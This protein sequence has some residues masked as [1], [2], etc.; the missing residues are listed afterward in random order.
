MFSQARNAYNSI[1]QFVRHVTKNT[2]YL[3]NFPFPELYKEVA[4]EESVSD[5]DSE[6]AKTTRIKPKSKPRVLR[7]HKKP[8][9][10]SSKDPIDEKGDEGLAT[11]TAGIPTLPRRDNA[12][13]VEEAVTGIEESNKEEGT[14]T[15][16]QVRER[17]NVLCIGFSFPSRKNRM[18][19]YSDSA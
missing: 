4:V 3:V 15:A 7:F 8:K 13:V 16:P 10:K 2:A 1:S 12:A 18:S 9:G 14:S 6:L 17:E 19:S 11:S 5:S